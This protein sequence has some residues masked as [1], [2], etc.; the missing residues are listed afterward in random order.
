VKERLAEST[1]TFLNP[2]QIHNAMSKIHT[3]VKRLLGI[4]SLHRKHRYF[5]SNVTAKKGAKSFT[6]KEK[7]LAWAKEQGLDSKKFELHT[8]QNGKKFQ[9]RAIPR[10]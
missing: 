4:T 5:F 1:A 8:L 3:R 10:E 2:W 6:D 7:A 9:W